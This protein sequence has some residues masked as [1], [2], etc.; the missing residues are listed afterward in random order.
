MVINFF[1]ERE[2]LKQSLKEAQDESERL[3]AELE[4]ER[5]TREEAERK[6]NDEAERLRSALEEAERK[7]R[8]ESEARQKAHDEAERLREELKHEQEAHKESKRMYQAE[9]EDRRNAQ[10]DAYRLRLSLEREQK[11]HEEATRKLQA[12]SDALRQEAD[13]LR[14]ELQ[15]K[16]QAEAD[17]KQKAQSFAELEEYFNM[18]PSES[19]VT[20]KYCSQLGTYYRLLGCLRIFAPIP[21]IYLVAK[22]KLETA[23]VGYVKEKGDYEEIREFVVAIYLAAL[24]VAISNKLN[25]TSLTTIMEEIKS[26]ISKRG[27]SENVSAAVILAREDYERYIHPVLDKLEKAGSLAA[28]LNERLLSDFLETAKEH[29][30]NL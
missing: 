24:V 19:E 20:R 25:T 3:R 15:C 26:T 17:E 2:R 6:A 12:E 27:F 4:Q 30:F 1:R 9:V 14:A 11:A 29:P 23:I 13:N 16:Y 18:L 21:E 7:Y 10:E 22:V 8:S 5:R 28:I